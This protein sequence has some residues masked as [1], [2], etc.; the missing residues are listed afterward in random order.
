MSREN[1]S[2]SGERAAVSGYVAQYDYFAKKAYDALILDDL[3]TVQVANNN[4]GILDDIY[5][6]TRE[7]VHVCQMKHSLLEKSAFSYADFCKLLPDIVKSWKEIAQAHSKKVVPYLITNRAV[8]C[9]DDIRFDDGSKAGS[10]FDFER[11]VLKPLAQGALISPEWDG[12]FGNLKKRIAEETAVADSDVDAFF[13]SFVT[14][15]A[16]VPELIEE[17]NRD[18]VRTGDI[19][20]LYRLFQETAASRKRN[21]EL[22]AEE[23]IDILGWK[24]RCK[25]IFEQKLSIN[26]DEIVPIDKTRKELEEKINA[27]RSGYLFLQGSPGSGKSTTLTEWA[28]ATKC[29]TTFYYAFDFTDSS[30][31]KNF[32]SRGE[33]VT[34]LHDLVLQLKKKGFYYK[35]NE[36]IHGDIKFLTDAFY[37]QLR[38]LHED[39]IHNGVKH[40]I[41][42]DGLDHVPR[43]Y[44]DCVHSLIAHLPSVAKLT[45]GVIVLLGSQTF[46]GLKDLPNDVKKEYE[47]AGNII[48]MSPLSY[49]DTVELAR[50]RFGAEKLSEEIL[51]S[52]FE[53]THGHPLYTNYILR[54]INH[55]GET[56]TLIA[57]LPDYNGD[58][59]VYYKSLINEETR[60]Q[61]GEI[62]GVLARCERHL[63]ME[64]FAEW[65]LNLTQLH[66][67]R[68]KVRPLLAFDSDFDSFTFFHNSFRIYLIR[69]TS[70]NLL[71][72]KYD[73]SLDGGYYS[74]LADYYLKSKCE[75]RVYAAP[76]LFHARRFEE[77]LE[78]SHPEKLWVALKNFVPADE[79]VKI[80]ILG[81]K[82]A[83]EHRDIY[84]LCRYVFMLHQLTL[85][86]YNSSTSI[87]LVYKDL[88]EAGE[89]NVLERICDAPEVALG[90]IEMMMNWADSL[91]RDGKVELAR[92]VFNLCWDK[93]LSF[94]VPCER[95][96]HSRL[97]VENHLKDVCYMLKTATIFISLPEIRKKYTEYINRCFDEFEEMREY[98]SEEDLVS[99][100]ESYIGMGFVCAAQWASYD[101]ILTS[102][103]LLV[104]DR[105][106]L[107]G[108]KLSQLLGGHRNED[109]TQRAFYDFENNF[110]DESVNESF[111]LIYL[112]KSGVLLNLYGEKQVGDIIDGVNPEDFTAIYG[113]LY[114]PNKVNCYRWIFDY[115]IL[116][117]FSN[118]EETT[119][120][121]FRIPHKE[122]HGSDKYVD[123][124]ISRIEV[125]ARSC[126][127]CRLEK[128]NV[129]DFEKACAS[130]LDVYISEITPQSGID[131]YLVLGGTRKKCI[132]NMLRSA[133]E[134]GD[135]FFSVA[136][137]VFV[138][139]WKNERLLLPTADVIEVLTT[140]V[141][142]HADRKAIR[143]LLP[144]V[145][146]VFFEYLSTDE[147][148][149]VCYKLGQ[150]YHRLGEDGHARAWYSKMIESTFG[151]AYRKDY[152]IRT[153]I[154]W[155]DFIN[156][157]DAQK[158]SERLKWVTQRLFC[159]NNTTEG[160]YYESVALL[161]S[162]YKVGLSCGTK[163]LAWMW[164]TLHISF[165]SGLCITLE[166]VLQSVSEEKS[167]MLVID[168][169]KDV[170][171][172]SAPE[173]ERIECSKLLTQIQKKVEA[174][175]PQNKVN[176][177][178]QEIEH[179]IMTNAVSSL[180]ARLLAI[181]YKEK[182]KNEGEQE[183]IEIIEHEPSDAELSIIQAENLLSEGRKE[184]AQT[185][186]VSAIGQSRYTGWLEYW[187]G[188]TKLKALNVL[189]HLD[190][191]TAYTCAFDELVTDVCANSRNAWLDCMLPF[192][193]FFEGRYDLLPAFEE[194]EAYMNRLIRDTDVKTEDV[195]EFDTA[196]V[197]AHT[198]IYR[199]LQSLSHLN[200]AYFNEAVSLIIARDCKRHGCVRGAAADLLVVNMPICLK[201]AGILKLISSELYSDVKSVI[202]VCKLTQNELTI[203]ERVQFGC[204]M[205]E[206]M[207]DDT[208]TSG[209]DAHNSNNEL[210]IES[211]DAALAYF[212]PLL[213]CIAY[214][215]KTSRG[216]LQGELH[217]ILESH[218]ATNTRRMMG[219]AEVMRKLESI[220]ARFSYI[221]PEFVCAWNVIVQLIENLLKNNRLPKKTLPEIFPNYNYSASLR[222]DLVRPDF[223]KVDYSYP[224]SFPKDAFMDSY[225]NREIQ[226]Y[227]GL[228]V[229]AE[230]TCVYWRGV[231]F[232][233]EHRS[234]FLNDAGLSGCE[235][236]L[237]TPMWQT[238]MRSIPLIFSRALAE[239]L[240]WT[241]QND[242]CTMWKNRKGDICVK[243]VYWRDGNCEQYSR[244]SC[245]T[246]EG[247][248]LLLTNE[249]LNEIFEHFG[250]HE[251]LQAKRFVVGRGNLQTGWIIEDRAG[252]PV[253]VIAPEGLG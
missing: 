127:N 138:S 8:S 47:E 242:E 235:E 21:F 49:A 147:R 102:G 27:K 115:L 154:E 186:I 172:Y 134:L 228:N 174:V 55:H 116:R 236:Y 187:D 158:A 12:I 60:E 110:Q 130:F 148:V 91:Y 150:L 98:Y 66:L 114:G 117:A 63:S 88:Y 207:Q 220:G 140:A 81:V 166:Y 119:T 210:N 171:L 106:V 181:L 248:L 84:C 1:V 146:E 40:V 177:I 56:T 123:I 77:F 82:V 51:G 188:G 205:L 122:I 230:H 215:S 118:K 222:T 211:V 3:V 144:S 247:W 14:K 213:E 137:K 197:D 252:N 109:E 200:I 125:F 129:D 163:M 165:V 52:I 2:A 13:Q 43:E 53:R 65:G 6:E 245:E 237:P 131:T 182:I 156:G 221:S 229:I 212:Y 204:F 183:S 57:N 179:A 18:V 20:R 79:I 167:L 120:S 59:E 161:N 37:E 173:G 97:D 145:E 231:R 193:R 19:L 192:L 169:F 25:T 10:F 44:V 164:N 234:L 70:R 157:I 74:K 209:K 72:D 85:M 38:A 202:S 42:I 226:I 26:N 227:D 22:T 185:C 90:H 176:E 126:S 121:R 28:S 11:E 139:A 95:G 112:A 241:V 58:I 99:L 113:S 107:T 46:N 159:V 83:K 223:T 149:D 253:P 208:P 93:E 214:F 199:V 251:L 168:V 142:L 206:G 160:G 217:K 16:Y 61:L 225:L 9:H 89:T 64:F 218:A 216:I 62:L 96:F 162:A 39:Y 103:R 71:T 36:L 135:D 31:E 101:E 92:R 238:L 152:Q 191:D 249:G 29:D 76:Y 75:N 136:Y 15:F 178:Y 30:R 124:L 196:E 190:E 45:D 194:L 54:S 224:S 153:F 198:A 170:Y 80:S 50:K 180:R 143:E 243:S 240:D 94:F 5:V 132:Q 32:Y 24:N 203:D 141:D 4:N 189:K 78:E 105:T 108:Y 250:S 41:I 34:M 175:M 69:E 68:A 233:Y 244:D 86:E 87:N 239:D 155:I 246:A 67:M 201:V 17:K 73:A 184:E 23:I 219:K 100:F 151:L 7:F 133:K 48:T 232:D 33:A 35:G 195:P 111:S 104:A 128:E